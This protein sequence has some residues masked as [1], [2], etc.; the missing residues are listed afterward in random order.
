MA[1]QNGLDSW[2]EAPGVI[3]DVLKTQEKALDEREITITKELVENL[4]WM[5]EIDD[6]TATNFRRMVELQVLAWIRWIQSVEIINPLETQ[7]DFLRELSFLCEAND[8]EVS[9]NRAMRFKETLFPDKSNSAI[10]RLL[11]I[12][13]KTFN[14]YFNNNWWESKMRDHLFQSL[15]MYIEKNL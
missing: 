10:I 9:K 13:S 4:L 3:L 2:V 12:W 1:I 7:E 8:G 11:N 5:L 14:D 15:K 6:T